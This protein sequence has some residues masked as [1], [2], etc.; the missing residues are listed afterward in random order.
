MTT[1]ICTLEALQYAAE[2]NRSIRFRYVRE[3]VAAV[4]LEDAREGHPAFLILHQGSAIAFENVCPHRAT[5]LDW[6]PGDVFDE[7]GLYLICATH[8]ALFLP[9]TGVCVSGPCTKQQL[10]KVAVITE[11]G[12]VHLAG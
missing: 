2:I 1:L 10:K 3:P 7:S 5:E 8:G 4:V 9:A 11:K 12:G 6:N